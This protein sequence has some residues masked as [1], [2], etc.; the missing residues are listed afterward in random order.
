MKPLTLSVPEIS[1]VFQGWGIKYADEK[2]SSPPSAFLH[3]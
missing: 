3:P 2:N 1:Q